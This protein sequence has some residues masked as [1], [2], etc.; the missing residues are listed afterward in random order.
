MTEPKTEYAVQLWNATRDE[1]Y[2]SEYEE[3]GDVN[4]TVFESMEIAEAQIVRLNKRFPNAT[5]RV[6][7]RVR[8]DWEPA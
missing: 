5:Y 1:G 4:V 3:W 8:S 2:W 6:A 7:K